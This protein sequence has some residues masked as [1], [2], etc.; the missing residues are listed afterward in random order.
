MTFKTGQDA[1]SVHSGGWGTDVRHFA[2][3]DVE[4]LEERHELPYL[5]IA[6]G[7]ED[8]PRISLEN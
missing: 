5:A 7:M 1:T 8:G 3:I 2:E 4:G 6:L